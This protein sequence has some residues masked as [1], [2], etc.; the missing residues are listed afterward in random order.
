MTEELETADPEDFL[1]EFHEMDLSE[2]HD[3][4]FL[5]AQS[6]GNPQGPKYVC[7]TIR[8]PFAFFEMVEEVATMWRDEQV[9]AKAIFLEKDREKRAR[10]LDE[11]TIDFIEAR[12]EEILTDG[13][14]SGD[15]EGKKYDYKAGIISEDDLDGEE[16]LGGEAN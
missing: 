8:G 16:D 10:W 9:H 3:S 13:F 7:S 2:I 5:V 12:W 6:T 15:L 1:G 4:V 11:P 14:L